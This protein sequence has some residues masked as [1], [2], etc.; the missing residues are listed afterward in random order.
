MHITTAWAGS[1]YLLRATDGENVAPM[2]TKAPYGDNSAL[3]PKQLCLAAITGCTGMDVIVHFQ[4]AKQA[5]GSLRIE[6]E[7]PVT[8]TKPAIFESVTL[9]YFFEGA[10]PTALALDAV[11]HSQTVECGVS[12]MIARACPIYYKVHVNGS[13]VGQGEA[14][15][16]R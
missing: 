12:A 1:K 14:H 9:D 4:K 10:F 15:F 3:S 5:L 11:Q 6:A 16:P 13:L 7:A 2:D 8:K